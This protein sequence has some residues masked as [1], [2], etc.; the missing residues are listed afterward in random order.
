MQYYF[1]TLS[2]DSDPNN[3]RYVGVTTRLLKQRMYGHRYNATKKEKRNQPVHKWMWSVI[4]KGDTVSIHFLDE[5]DET[6]WEDREKYWIKYYKDLGYKLLNVQEGGAGIVT[7]EMRKKDGIQRSADAH[8]KAVCQIDPKTH[9]LIAVHDSIRSA[10]KAMG[11]NS[12]SAIGNALSK[13]NDTVLSAGYYWVYKTDYDNGTFKLKEIDPYAH[14]TSPMVY[15]FDLNGSLMG[16]YHGV[17]NAVLA[18]GITSLNTQALNLAIKQKT[19]YHKSYWSW[20]P[21]I[22]IKE[23]KSFYKYQEIDETGNIVNQYL[24]HQEIAKVH[25]LRQSA[26][27]KKIKKESLFGKNKIIKIKI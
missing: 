3:I 1:Y 27:S 24:T 7:K 26:V 4:E 23:F 20:E 15:R 6:L 8:K 9:Q 16:S 5:C 25:N 22:N 2:A 11:L 12:N 14:I 13:T 19:V 18:L 10:T 21:S 17:S